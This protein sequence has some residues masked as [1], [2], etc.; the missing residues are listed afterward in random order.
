MILALLVASGAVGGA[1]RAQNKFF[2]TLETPTKLVERGFF[3]GPDFG[4][5]FPVSN[6]TSLQSLGWD[7]T[8]VVTQRN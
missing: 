4:V 3:M 5:L 6:K 7:F 2:G 8:E 1:A